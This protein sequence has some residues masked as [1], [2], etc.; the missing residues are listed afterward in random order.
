MAVNSECGHLQEFMDSLSTTIAIKTEDKMITSEL[1]EY[2]KESMC[3]PVSFHR[4]FSSVIVI[5]QCFGLMPVSGITG[6]S[7]SFIR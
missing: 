6:P 4:S 3:K 1:V 7:A 5:A 2:K